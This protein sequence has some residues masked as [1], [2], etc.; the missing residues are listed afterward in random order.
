[1]LAQVVKI[2]ELNPMVGYDSIE[3][4]SVLGWKVVVKKGEHQ[5]G[6]LACYCRIGS[7]LPNS[8][9]T[10]FLNGKPLKTKKFKQYISQGLIVPLEWAGMDKVEE[11]MDVTEKIGAT[12][13]IPPDEKEIYNEDG[14]K[15]AWYPLVPKQT[16]S[17]PRDASNLY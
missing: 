16:K 6:D 15:A 4:A 1:M 2:T 3:L 12:R 5:V 8:G 10:A 14:T 11:D 7:C 9:N 17:V 13:Y